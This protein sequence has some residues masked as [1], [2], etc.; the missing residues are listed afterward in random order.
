M[1]AY[2]LFIFFLSIIH[3]VLFFDKSSGL[4]VLLFIIPLLFLLVTILIKNKKVKNKK[5]LLFLIPIVLLSSSY[6]IYDNAFTK[7]MN[8]VVIPLLILL[9]YIFTLKPTNEITQ[10]LEDFIYLIF[11]PFNCIGKFY[12]LVGLKISNILKLS[13][14]SKKRIKALLI[15]I[16]IVIIVLALLSSADMIFG[17]A[18]SNIFKVFKHI[19]IDNIFG[20]IIRIIIIFT[21]IGAVTNYLVFNFSNKKNKK[22]KK[23]NLDSYTIKLLLTVLNIIY[24]VFDFIQ[25]KSLMLHQVAKSINYAEYARSGFFQLMFI[26]LINITII[27][28]SKHAKEESKYSK[29]MSIVMIILTL[30]I[31]VSS[32]LRMHMY[33]S[34]YGYTLLRLLVYTILFTETV[35]FIPTIV[36]ILNSKVNIL[37][38]YLII[39]TV[40]YTALCLSPID[41][42]IANNNINRY[43]KTNKIDINYLQ[44]YHSDNVPLLIEFHDKTKNQFFKHSIEVYLKTDFYKT[45]GFQEYNLS[46]N[47]AKTIIK[48]KQ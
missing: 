14:N 36:Y 3:S 41:Y 44:N 18:F 13:E 43:Y 33:E 37:K 48:L 35:L 19:K 39:T 31:I 7:G 25:I 46:K 28:V 30:I 9:M 16:P 22:T 17:S 40:V 42:I 45:N 15:V 32:A 5:G 4:N 6:F 11:E 10:I 2:I 26:S 47:K 23:S 34:A 38:Y 1:S 29:T 21:Y 8:I 24:I 20:R 12:N 27:L